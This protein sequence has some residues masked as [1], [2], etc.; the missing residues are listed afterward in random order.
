MGI[1]IPGELQWVAQYLLGAGDWPDGD[2]TAMRRVADGW[3]AMA[4]TLDTVDDDAAVALNA[5]LTA[6]SEGETHT[7]IATFRDRFLAGDQAT[8]TAV[9][10][11]CR[12]Q[13]EL[14]DDGANDIE[15]TKLVIIGTMIVTAAE[16]AVALATSWTGVGAVA[17]VAARV[18]GQIAIRIAIKQLIAR[19]LSRGA[20]K[21]A[22]RLALRGA[23]FEALEEGG[24]DLAA[25]MIQVSNG[26]R[27]TDKFGWTDLGLATFGGAVGGAV[28]GVLGGGTGALA[29]TA[30]STVGKVAGKVAGGAVTELGADVSA[31]VAA[32]GVGAA[33]LGQEFNLD[34]GV[35]TF[36]SAG[37]GGVQSAVESGGSSPA[38]AP[39]VPE[40][41]TE[42]PGATTPAATAPA[43]DS[44]APGSESPDAPT[45]PASTDAPSGDQPPTGTDN[46]TPDTPAAPN[47]DEPTNPASTGDPGSPT[48]GAT[49]P[50]NTA[51]GDPATASPNDNGANGT[52]SPTESAPASAPSDSAPDAG[53]TSPTP[54]PDTHGSPTTPNTGDATQS[55]PNGNPDTG[56]STPS[57]PENSGPTQNPAPADT[58]SPSPTTPVTPS[59]VDTTPTN[60]TPPTGDTIPT[61]SAP[62]TGDTT[63]LSDPTN[64][65]T[66]DTPT[67]GDTRPSPTNTPLDLPAQTTAADPD[68]ANTPPAQ[69][70]PTSATPPV[71]TTPDTQAATSTPAA[72]TPG[73]SPTTTPSNPAITQTAPADATRPTSPDTSTAAAT[74]TTTPVSHTGTPA[75][76]TTPTTPPTTTPASTP[77]PPT[78]PSPTATPHA[79]PSSPIPSVP[80]SPR[81][82]TA[83]S[84]TPTSTPTS[85]QDLGTSPTPPQ[86]SNPN[87][88]FG[89]NPTPTTGPIT[90]NPTNPPPHNQARAL[91]ESLRNLPSQDGRTTAVDANRSPFL[92]RPPAYRIRR[93]HLGGNQWVAAA[94]V[95]AHIPNAHL[96]SPAELS[97]AMERIQATVDA[98]FNDGSKLLS[99]DLFLVD[100]E[101]TTDPDNADLTLNPNEHSI[102]QSNVLREHLGLFPAEP[103]T[104]LNP[105]DLREISNDIA[106]ANTPTRFA[107]PADSRVI[108]HNHLDD[109]E[110][111]TYQAHVE[112]L[113]RE[114]N[115]FVTGADPRTHPYGQAINDGG[116]GQPGRGNNCLD[117]SLSALS[118]FFGIPRIAAPRWP[119]HNQDG[120]PDSR[121]GEQ[122]GNERAAAWIGSDWV[123][124]SGMSVDAEYQALHDHVANLGPGSAALVATG[125]HAR[126]ANGVRRYHADGTPV[127]EEGHATV[128]VFPPGASGPVWWDPQSGETSD[129]PPASL[130]A[131]AAAMWCIPIDANGGPLN[132]GTSTYP[133]ASPTVAGPSIRPEHGVQ[134]PGEQPRLDMSRDAPAGDSTTDRP[135]DESGH[136]EL[137]GQQAHGS[138]H[139]P[140]EHGIGGDRQGVRPDDRSRPPASGL[141]GISET[142]PDSPDPRLR[143]PEYD[144]LS[145]APDVPGESGQPGDHPGRRDHQEPDPTPADGPSIGS[146]DVMGLRP[147][148]QHGDMAGGGHDRAIADHDD[149]TATESAPEPMSPSP[150]AIDQS[151]GAIRPRDIFDTPAQDA[152][153]ETVYEQVRATDNDV[154]AMAE[155]LADTARPDGTRGYSRD[156]IAQVKNHLFRS[157]H[158]LAVYD[159][160]GNTV[161]V[162]M[163]RYDASADIA[164]A[165]MRLS[166][167]TARPEDM[168]LLEHELA[169]AAYYAAH[170]GASYREAH[171]HA[172]THF[173]WESNIPPRTGEN[174]EE[175][176]T[177]HGDQSAVPAQ[178]GDR[179]GRDIPVRQP[180]PTESR[181]DDPQVGLHGDRGG[182]EDGPAGDPH[183]GQGD[184]PPQAGRNLDEVGQRPGL[185]SPRQSGGE[186]WVPPQAGEFDRSSSESAS[187][188]HSVVAAGGNPGGTVPQPTPTDAPANTP[189]SIPSSTGITAAQ[190]GPHSPPPTPQQLHNANRSRD[191][192]DSLRSQRPDGGTQLV[193]DPS[194]RR[195][196]TW[197]RHTT[198]L[199]V[200]VSVLRIG[201]HLTGA[202]NLDPAAVTALLQRAQLATDLHFNSGFQLPNGDWVMVD[203]VPLTDPSAAEMHMRVDDWGRP[204]ATHPNAELPPLTAQLREQL[205][206]D[207]NSDQMSVVD[208]HRLGAAVDRATFTPPP[209]PWLANPSHHTEPTPPHATSLPTR[210]QA[211]PADPDNRGQ[212]PIPPHRDFRAP[213]SN[214]PPQ[215]DGQRPHDPRDFR[216]PESLPPLMPRSALPRD[217]SPAPARRTTQQSGGFLRRMVR[218]LFGTQPRNVPAQPT[219]QR[220]QQP[221]AQPIQRAALGPDRR[222][223][224]V[225]PPS[226]DTRGLQQPHQP[227]DFTDLPYNTGPPY[228]TQEMSPAYR[229]E[230]EEVNPVWEYPLCVE[231]LDESARQSYRLFVI[232]GELWTAGG[233]RFD[234]RS[235]TT[236][237]GEGRAVFVMDEQGNLYA[238][239][240]HE[241]GMFHHSSF[242]SGGNVAAAGELIVIDG[243]LQ[244]LTDSS[245]HYR[246]ARG[247]TM[248]AINQLRSM[249]IPITPGQVRFEAPPQ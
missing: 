137:R 204:G 167:G 101:F 195:R 193:T 25:R 153:A 127:I 113:L 208:L 40:L 12:T 201:L 52:P 58:P 66:P 239:T 223:P 16:L 60:S 142:T 36:T 224:A 227:Q 169:E 50:Q 235:G 189:G 124:Y 138:D 155:N 248:Q 218:R 170:P 98:T 205:G 7:A 126:D 202:P 199:G 35:D 103:N 128:V 84:S 6:I 245:G 27:T 102:R 69:Q 68:P 146:S 2:E 97:Q 46:G 122:D 179:T 72:T 219:V 5:A 85:Q 17:G 76:A 236:A 212:L 13:A 203:L 33:F 28:G 54:N 237:R 61:N 192:R 222:P 48:D 15:H 114:G 42:V 83:I 24:V 75:P 109:I 51:P 172:N 229:G 119:D 234:T 210:H 77:A 183:R 95:R 147:E 19:M 64:G 215:L 130:T 182:R 241:R 90:H 232:D 21:A 73:I 196:F 37:A 78:T 171:D 177:R 118:S 112:D 34:I 9:R 41:G 129:T 150:S 93:F 47:N 230:H 121:S 63:Q 59:P 247:H 135:T 10:T 92:Q 131:E 43:T 174:I 211:L 108:D 8:V 140:L 186:R 188:G 240:Y 176:K 91:R 133:G 106:R 144:H 111:P 217:I 175:W 157:E 166:N 125:W 238:S 67:P 117:C 74:T 4:N 1:E 65:T 168:V 88:P 110:S 216:A 197:Q 57:S 81:S 96:M 62:S 187:S 249:G 160:D 242:L 221:A 22:A 120:T 56:D 136:G 31:Q 99:G 29:D 18:A 94:T 123:G 132:G 161:G 86:S 32:A 116:R 151:G 148:P 100:L 45:T 165:W 162:E 20:A 206:L 53:N 143:G 82:T 198:A 115:S 139:G 30:G 87:Q 26:D 194:G 185:D 180:G 152:W 158:P 156:E 55:S 244:L 200:P 104:T 191:A 23:A 79:S 89:P 14:L 38:Q 11:W 225:L 71:T 231:Y 145:S 246:P 220:G 233:V 154:D 70:A 173:N 49:A 44:P 3:T 213:E 163:R 80:S 214:P 141:S 164:E 105:D 181:A 228:A 159:D 39:T 178:D 243:V 149:T 190:V 226:S 207:P 184:E 134:H 107:D 209:P